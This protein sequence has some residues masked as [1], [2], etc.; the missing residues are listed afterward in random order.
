MEH[1][2]RHMPTRQAPA[3]VKTNVLMIHEKTCSCGT[4]QEYKYTYR[5]DVAYFRK[6]EDMSFPDILQEHVH[7]YYRNKSMQQ[8]YEYRHNN[9]PVV[10]DQIRYGGETIH[11]HWGQDNLDDQK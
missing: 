4:W 11:Q 9:F 10:Q 1:Q 2:Q 8:I 3:R 5:H 6:W 7:E